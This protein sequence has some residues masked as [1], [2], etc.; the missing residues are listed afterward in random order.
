MERK[1]LAPA[2][3]QSC[4]SCAPCVNFK[5]DADVW[6][7]AR[8]PNLAVGN[9]SQ[10]CLR[11]S[12]VS[13]EKRQ[14]VSYFKELKTKHSGLDWRFCRPAWLAS[15]RGAHLSTLGILNPACFAHLLGCVNSTYLRHSHPPR[16]CVSFLSPFF[17]L[18]YIMEKMESERNTKLL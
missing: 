10:V 4:P 17:S 9:F 1:G 14:T 12:C 16:A 5:T 15:S 11:A 8:S 2:Q 18:F 3:W 6:E 13:W 7:L